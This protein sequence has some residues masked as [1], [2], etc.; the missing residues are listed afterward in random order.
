MTPKESPN[1]TQLLLDWRSGDK[2]ALDKLL[3]LVHAEMS[4]LAKHYMRRERAGHT[5][6]T[7]AL[8]NEAYLR[9]VDHKN[10]QWQNRAHFFGVAAQAMRRILVDHARRRG[11]LKRGGGAKQ[12]SLDQAAIVPEKESEHADIVALDAA[13][14]KLGEFDPRKSRIIELR[15]FGGLSV[16]ETAEVMEVSSVTIKRE[17]STARAWLMREISGE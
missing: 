10:I 13:L 1:V 2:T 4:R 12:V 6:Q 3:P 17:W 16:E 14:D 9:L 15:Y 5:L 8:V 11:Y 7:S